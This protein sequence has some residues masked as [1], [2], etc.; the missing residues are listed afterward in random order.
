MMDLIAGFLFTTGTQKVFSF[1]PF[2]TSPPFP[3]AIPG[4]SASITTI[5][6]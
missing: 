2:K 1:I 3:I 5:D 4:F 6:L